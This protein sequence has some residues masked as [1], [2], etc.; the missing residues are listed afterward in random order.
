MSDMYTSIFKTLPIVT[1]KDMCALMNLNLSR[2]NLLFSQAEINKAYRIRALQFH[3]D[4]QLLAAQTLPIELSNR[5]M[6]DLVRCR[7]H[8]LKGEE[9]IIGKS[10]AASATE[11]WLSQFLQALET[12][13]QGDSNL[14]EQIVWFSRFSRTAVMML[15]LSTFS[16]G[17][18]NMRYL[19]QFAPQLDVLRAMLGSLNRELIYS[20]LVMIQR[21]V[22]GGEF[23][24]HNVFLGIQGLI[25]DDALSRQGMRT[26]TAAMH[27]ARAELKKLLT[28]DFIWQIDL[29]LNFWPDF[30]ANL[31]SWSHLA[32]TFFIT[33]LI[34]ATS[35]PKYLNALRVFVAVILQQKGSIALVLSSPLLLLLG[36]GLLPINVA[37]HVF[38]QL[39]WLGFN[40]AFTVLKSVLILLFMPYK[41]LFSESSQAELLF[42]LLNALLDLSVR[43]IVTST[44]ELFDGLLFILSDRSLVSSWVEYFNH[45]LDELLK[46]VKPLSSASL[47]ADSEI[48]INSDTHQPDVALITA[49]LPSVLPFFAAIPLHNKEDEFLQNIHRQIAQANR[50]DVNSSEE[51]DSINAAFK[52]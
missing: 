36:I 6:D 40:A 7:E 12:L 39:V 23:D 46:A 47:N 43:L 1:K 35:L 11:D 13:K 29:I 24:E 44:L 19:N 16:D 5:L 2:P 34:T 4:R 17:Q 26:L 38:S 18:L 50:V 41:M 27:K 25:P 20:L 45:N 33:M 49:E 8:L 48:I 52:A 32:A 37:L 14:A 42:A 30:L 15:A 28:D 51:D 9:N 21:F 3:P 22:A 31:P 10:F